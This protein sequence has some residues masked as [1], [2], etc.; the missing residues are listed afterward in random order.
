MKERLIL[1]ALLGYI[2]GII[3]G[4]YLKINIALFYFILFAIY[5]IFI[6]ENKKEKVFK[7]LS[8]K[9]YFKY[10]KL[11]INSKTI[12]VFIIFSIIS[13]III[14]IQEQGYEKQ[15][16]KTGITNFV[17]SVESEKEEGKFYD[18]FKVKNL[19]KEKYYFYIQVK[20]ELSKTIQFG[21][22]IEVEGT[23]QKITGQR[24]FGGFNYQKYLKTQGI[25]RNSKD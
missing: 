3:W 13:N 4:L 20:K 2:I 18:K 10:F 25:S 14:C 22:I 5:F 19:N 17:C 11:V 23:Y 7:P 9:R 8:I 24:N 6:R 16:K 1:V 21:D 15:Y 12:I